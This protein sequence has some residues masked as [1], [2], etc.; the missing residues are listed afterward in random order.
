MALLNISSRRNWW[1]AGIASLMLLI[2]GAFYAL[3]QPLGAHIEQ[4]IS[5]EARHG[6]RW[7]C[8]N[9]IR[10][11]VVPELVYQCDKA[12]L[13]KPVSSAEA[14]S[15]A[16]PL[17]AELAS[18]RLGWSP[19]TPTSARLAASAPLVGTF[20]PDNLPFNMDW[21]AL[22]LTVDGYSTRSAHAQLRLE[23]VVAMMG[24]PATAVH[25]ADHMDM[26][27][28]PLT[29]AGDASFLPMSFHANGVKTPILRQILRNDTP[30]SIDFQGEL[31]DPLVLAG[32]NAFESLEYWRQAG[33]LIHIQ[34][35]HLAA[36][37]LNIMAEGTLALDAQHRLS[38]ALNVT[39]H[40]GEALL[41]SY[42]YAPKAG[43]AGALLGGLL[44]S[45]DISLLLRLEE[46]HVMLGPLKLPVQ[47][48]ALY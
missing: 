4:F 44:K 23:Q 35:L 48:I 19:W 30:V 9:L 46:G 45:K 11:S 37:D 43:F 40:G 15:A 18:L 42:G 26:E 38:G 17:V 2:A 47:L 8:G 34:N 29:Q 41:S 3:V 36:T 32:A 39:I 28:G 20:G 10:Q 13:N 7:S 1:L 25:S 22:N 6:R 5:G 33:G 16:A 27:T 14:V 12:G 31:R 21:Q 24:A